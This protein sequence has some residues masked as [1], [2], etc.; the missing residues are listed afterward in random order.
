MQTLLAPFF[1][2]DQ[3]QVD[4]STGFWRWFY[5]YQGIVL[6]VAPV[7]S[8][9][10]GKDGPIW[11]AK[12]KMRRPEREDYNA[13]FNLIWSPKT[14]EVKKAVSGDYSVKLEADYAPLGKISSQWSVGN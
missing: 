11:L 8:I 6:P 1:A 5:R 14:L 2:L 13:D 7:V 10:K 4:Q 3:E 9:R 12:K